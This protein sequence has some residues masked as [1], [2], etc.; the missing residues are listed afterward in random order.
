MHKYVHAQD[1][2]GTVRTD[3]IEK[4]EALQCSVDT[5]STAAPPAKACIIGGC[6]E[7]SAAVRAQALI[8]EIPIQ[9]VHIPKCG[10]TFL[11]TGPQHVLSEFFG[12]RW[13]ERADVME[14]LGGEHPLAYFSKKRETSTGWFEQKVHE[15]HMSKPPDL[16]VHQLAVVWVRDPLERFRSGFH[17]V[18][19]VV[20]TDVDALSEEAWNTI[21]PENL[22]PPHSWQKKH[23]GYFASPEMDKLLLHF[24]DANHFAE[25]LS[26][27]GKDGELACELFKRFVLP[28][29]IGFH[30]DNGDWVRKYPG[31]IFV[32]ALETMNEDLVRLA[33]LLKQSPKLDLPKVRVSGSEK[34]ALSELARRNLFQHLNHTDYAAFRAL[35]E[36]GLLHP[37]LYDLNP[38]DGIP[39]IKGRPN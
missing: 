37:D 15:A 34:S 11:N 38:Q 30:L 35:V 10:G 18:Q 12:R 6:G 3:E 13:F 22:S 24:R 27:S 26:A 23:K 36:A 25:S 2:S 17:F 14:G 20:R 39:K 28:T 19:K 31:Q 29:G 21:G 7:V 5:I 9:F 8:R 16:D 1:G 4:T 32:G 33:T